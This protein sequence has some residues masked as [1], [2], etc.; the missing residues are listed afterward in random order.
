MV[1]AVYLGLLS[2]LFIFQHKF[3]YM[4]LNRSLTATPSDWGLSYEDL[5]LVL[6]YLNPYGFQQLCQLS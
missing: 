5:F 2:L 1:V 3:I 6:G 4:P